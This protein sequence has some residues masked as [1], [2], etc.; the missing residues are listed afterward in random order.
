VAAVLPLFRS[1]PPRQKA[2]RDELP[3]GRLIELGGARGRTTLAVSM[4]IRAQRRDE[5]VA[6]VQRE[7]SAL[8]PPDLADSGVDLDALVVVHVPRRAGAAGAAKA[9]ELLLRSGAFGLVVID[10]AT[11]A[12]KG[13]AWQGRLSGLARQHG[14]Q[15]VLLTESAADAPS[16]GPLVSMRIVPRRTRT[17]PGRF[18][19]DHAI[20]K[21]KGGRTQPIPSAPHRAPAGLG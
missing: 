5:P 14:A 7:G 6:W 15:V 21:D 2:L 11:G 9:S 12:P 17:A 19:L 4:V 20:L 10:F 13:D 16:L 3:T 18:V 8:Y 1:E